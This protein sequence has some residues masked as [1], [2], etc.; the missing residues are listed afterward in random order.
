MESS[1]SIL[2]NGCFKYGQ[3]TIT[4]VLEDLSNRYSPEV[5]ESI[6]DLWISETSRAYKSGTK[7]YDS[8]IFRL[9]KV[10]LESNRL[11]LQTTNVTY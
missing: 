1:Y 4:H 9:N 6:N 10:I 3:V 2:A 7:I 5:I 8:N 11:N